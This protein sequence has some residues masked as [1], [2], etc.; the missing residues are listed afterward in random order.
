M[1][2]YVLIPASDASSRKRKSTA[3]LGKV[4]SQPCSADIPL[5]D[6]QAGLPAWV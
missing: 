5:G 3:R 6:L 4:R 2:V 1:A